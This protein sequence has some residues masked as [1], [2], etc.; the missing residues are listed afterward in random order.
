MKATSIETDPRHHTEKIRRMMNEVI[1]HVRADVAKVSEPKAQALFETT[2][3]VLSGLATAYEHYDAKAEPAWRE[4]LR[5]G[6]L[7]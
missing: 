6:S 4:A 2:A 1:Q 3:E 5:R 7:V